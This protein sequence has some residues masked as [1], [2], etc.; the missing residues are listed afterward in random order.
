MKLSFGSEKTSFL[1]HLRAFPIWEKLKFWNRS[2]RSQD[3][4]GQKYLKD[5]K[6]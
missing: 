2:W 4:E 5:W 6:L 1:T 3:S